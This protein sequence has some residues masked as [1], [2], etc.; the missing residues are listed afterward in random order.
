MV[1]ILV[2]EVYV[3]NDRNRIFHPVN[4]VLIFK[5]MVE[6]EKYIH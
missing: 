4:L 2:K 1:R 5:R 6:G 3:Q